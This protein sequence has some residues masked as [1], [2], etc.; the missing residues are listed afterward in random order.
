M[1]IPPNAGRPACPVDHAIALE[2]HVLTRAVLREIGRYMP[3]LDSGDIA[4]IIEATLWH[5]RRLA[6]QHDGVDLAYLGDLVPVDHVIDGH[7]TLVWLPRD[8]STADDK[9][10]D[11]EYAADDC[12]DDAPLPAPELIPISEAKRYSERELVGAVVVTGGLLRLRP[13]DDLEA[14][15]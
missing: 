14:R 15:S 3:T 2:D 4:W 12:A 7:R 1:T 11:P 8:D 13:L 5:L 6:E 10:A 9:T